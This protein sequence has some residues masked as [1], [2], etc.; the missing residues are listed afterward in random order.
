MAA[1]VTSK[2]RACLVA[3]PLVLALASLISAAPAPAVKESATAWTA[4][5]RRQVQSLLKRLNKPPLATFQAVQ[6]IGIAF[7]IVGHRNTEIS[8]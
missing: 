3:A 5:Q 6:S 4:A 1:A 8:V 7:C 2:R